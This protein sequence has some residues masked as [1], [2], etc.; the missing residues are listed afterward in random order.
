MCREMIDFDDMILAPLYFKA[1]F[2]PKDWILVDESQD[3]NPARR[4]L[5]PVTP[6]VCWSHDLRR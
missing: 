5:A 3:T 6:A 1:K 2:W 4:V